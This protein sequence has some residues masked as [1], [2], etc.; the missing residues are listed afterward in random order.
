[1]PQA[2]ESLMSA[3][4]LSLTAPQGLT[5]YSHN[6]AIMDAPI[7]QLLKRAHISF[8]VWY[9]KPA[10]KKSRRLTSPL[11][12]KNSNPKLETQVVTNASR[13]CIVFILRQGD[14]S[15]QWR[16]I[17]CGS[18]ALMIPESRCWVCEIEVLGLLYALSNCRHSL[19]GMF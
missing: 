18:R 14:L 8:G 6:L 13:V 15:G 2:A 16:L 17:Q 19:V 10:W 3:E 5:S 7:H 12:L 4:S 11:I 9:N 1:M